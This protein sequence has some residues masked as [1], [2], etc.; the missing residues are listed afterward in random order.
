M[1]ELFRLVGVL[2]VICTVAGALLA[3]VHGI[4]QAPIDAAAKQE[5]VDAVRDVLPEYDN[6]P[7]ADAVT[8]EHR[9]AEWT[10]YV[11][12]LNG[13]FNGAAF[14]TSSPKGYGGAISVMVGVRAG[15]A[16]NGIAIL[17]HQETPGLGAHIEGEAFRGQFAGLQ[18]DPTQWAVRKDGGDI[19]QITAATISSRAVVDAVEQGLQVYKQYAR[20]IRAGGEQW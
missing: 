5:T 10:F 18:P 8:V 9:G 12:K 2:F 14:E 17:R 3:F 16:L 13:A 6:D 11:A 1:K 19:D 7:V 4:T 15:G 20:M